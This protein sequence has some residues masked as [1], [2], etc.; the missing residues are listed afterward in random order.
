M[1]IVEKFAKAYEGKKTIVQKVNNKA[2]SD[3]P[4]N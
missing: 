2:Q 3:L 1:S 4:D